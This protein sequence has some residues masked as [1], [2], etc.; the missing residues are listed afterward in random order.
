M[1]R[2]YIVSFL[3]ILALIFTIIFSPLLYGKR[4]LTQAELAFLQ[5][6][7][8]SSVDLDRIRVKSGGPLTLVY[9]GITIGNT[10]SFPKDAYNENDQKDQALLVHELCHVWQYQHFGVGY[11]P[12][13]L[14]EL[15][16]QRDTYVIHYDATKSFREYDIEEQCEIVAEYFLTGDERYELYIEELSSQ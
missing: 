3:I 1:K 14:W 2:K 13:S 11:I 16:T 12:R 4:P 7:Y 5:P 10:I 9:P 6:I 8:Q 15:V